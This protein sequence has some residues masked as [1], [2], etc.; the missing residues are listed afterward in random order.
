M[1]STNHTPRRP[2][3][4][5]LKTAKDF[6]GY[7]DGDKPFREL[8]RAAGVEL[9]TSNNHKFY[10][11]S[12]IRKIRQYHFAEVVAS[13]M[14]SLPAII[15]ARITKG[16]TGKT[17]GVSNIGAVFAHMGYRTLL[18]DADS[19]GS[20]SEQMGYDIDRDDLTHIGHLLERVRAGRPSG[21]RD[22]VVPIYDDGML[23]LIPADITL[24]DEGWLL[25][26][27]GRE[28]LFHRLLQEEADF[29]SGY[30]VVLVDC[31]PGTTMLAGPI[32]AAAPVVTAI[33]MPEPQSVRAL[34]GLKSNLKELN[35]SVRAG[36]PI[37]LH[38]V[39]NGFNAPFKPHVENVEKIAR[40]YGRH[41]NDT[42]IRSYVG[43][44]RE[45]DADDVSTAIPLFEREP[46]SPGAR[47]IIG[48]TRTLVN[49]Y[50]IKL[51]SSTLPARAR[52]EDD[53]TV[54]A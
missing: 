25:M 34:R 17:T 10:L 12:E 15:P 41:L 26:A 33:V 21:V 44:K 28:S 6:L 50:G 20:L 38:I 19:Q 32:M 46:S 3:G 18:I 47:D 16:G 24:A 43:F 53:V 9:P 40:D 54:P 2:T 49:L 1:N 7:V 13:T 11:P 52:E 14:P 51:R 42:V 45:M 5:R 30:D 4:V 37:G 23:D 39:I 27:A 29:F 48:V 22:A 35:A 8:A 36:N 31:A